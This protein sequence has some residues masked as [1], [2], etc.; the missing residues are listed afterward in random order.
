MTDLEARVQLRTAEL[1]QA[2]RQLREM[3][4]SKSKFFANITHEL[5]TP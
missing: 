2:N 3:D 4:E 1:Q 5:R